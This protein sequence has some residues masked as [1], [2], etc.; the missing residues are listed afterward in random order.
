[1]TL[2]VSGLRSFDTI[3]FILDFS[4]RNCSQ[5]ADNASSQQIGGTDFKQ[6][7]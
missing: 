3:E 7:W 1:M 4:Q 5:Q 6:G 2:D